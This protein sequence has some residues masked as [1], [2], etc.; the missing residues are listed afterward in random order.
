MPQVKEALTHGMRPEQ[1][2]SM[3]KDLLAKA[4]TKRGEE[5]LEMLILLTGRAMKNNT[6]SYGNQQEPEKQQGY[7]FIKQ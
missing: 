7:Q 1:V 4:N 2:Q 6:I 5:G 3:Y